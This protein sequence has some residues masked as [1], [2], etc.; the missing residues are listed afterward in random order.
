M[1]N[2]GR[3]LM[4]N[5]LS[6]FTEIYKFATPDDV[7]VL[8][9]YKD[10]VYVLADTIIKE[11]VESMVGNKTNTGLCSEV[12]AHFK[13]RSYVKRT[14][15]NKFEGEIPVLNGLLN[16]N[17][18]Q[19][20]DFD[21]EKIFT[22]KV[23][24]RF[25]PDKDAPKFKA[26]FEQILPD[27]DDRTLFQEYAGYTL[28][29]AFPHHKFLILIGIG[30]NGKGVLIRTIVGVLGPDNVS[31]IRLEYLDG[32][33]R[34]TVAN[35]FG[36]LMNVCSE[37]STQRPFKTELLKQIT[38][39]DAL[40]GEIKNKQ[41]ALKFTPIAKFFIQANKLPIVDDKTLS[42]WDRVL[43]IECTETFTD[44]K[45]NKISDIEETWLNDEDERSGILNWMIEGLL[46]LKQNGKFTQTKSMDRTI[47]EFKQV[48]DPIGAF[49]ATPDQC[50]YGP[51]LWTT[52]EALYN[53]YKHH[54]EGIGAKIESPQTF[55]G[56]IKKTPGITERKKSINKKAVRIWMGISLADKG[57]SMD[58]F[59]EIEA[60]RQPR[61]PVPTGKV[62]NN[63]G[64]E[65]VRGASSAS[66]ASTSPER[67]P[68]SDVI[69]TVIRILEV[70][71]NSMG[72]D[73]F[74]QQIIKLGLEPNKVRYILKDDPRFILTPLSISFRDSDT[75]DTHEYREPEDL[76]PEPDEEV[77]KL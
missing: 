33:H 56:Q 64:K 31:N 63:I 20:R 72:I 61:H 6:K 46:R 45:G 9:L 5:I 73:F 26:A 29:P 18:M 62:N 74:N 23:A 32:S 68:G 30:R 39:K 12:I 44:E 51:L 36:K 28:L 24:T 41:N 1:V 21:P 11:E 17:T 58:D 59:D 76:G 34:F 43:I 47:I 14:K 54:A 3:D 38:G 69:D 35:L 42:F 10:G 40:D 8:Y 75:S 49:L 70:E 16:L 65:V 67:G 57:V 53:A 66:G 52:R 7:E 50:I 71:E 60:E 27:K 22:F 55:A 15:F 37:P 13:R 4:A 25:D 48:S 2:T 77:D 19:L